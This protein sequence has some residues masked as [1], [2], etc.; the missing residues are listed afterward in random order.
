VDS[1]RSRNRLILARKGQ[2]ANSILKTQIEYIVYLNIRIDFSM[3]S[4]G[5]VNFV[6]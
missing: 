4:Y 3:L 1:E 6:A 2:I 5:S